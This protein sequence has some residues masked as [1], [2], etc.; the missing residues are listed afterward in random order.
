MGTYVTLLTV[1]CVS[2]EL[3][4]LCSV[5]ILLAILH[6]QDSEKWWPCAHAWELP[7]LSLKS[8]GRATQ[9]F[10]LNPLTWQVAALGQVQKTVPLLAL[11]VFAAWGTMSHQT[12]AQPQ[13]WQQ[14]CEARTAKAARWP[15]SPGR[16]LQLLEVSLHKSLGRGLKYECSQR[17]KWVWNLALGKT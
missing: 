16:R 15:R 17:V 10:R 9:G 14:G 6:R 13:R 3:T 11:H 8:C 12:P 2:R 7:E 1:S 5:F 4:L